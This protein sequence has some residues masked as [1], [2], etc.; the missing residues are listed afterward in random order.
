TPSRKLVGTTFIP[1]ASPRPKFD[2]QNPF[3]PTTPKVSRAP[4]RSS[5]P[6]TPSTIIAPSKRTLAEAGGAKHSFVPPGTAPKK[7]PAIHAF[8]PSKPT[9]LQLTAD[10]DDDDNYISH[11]KTYETLFEET[12]NGSRLNDISETPRQGI[13]LSFQS[14]GIPETPKISI[15]LEKDGQFR[16]FTLDP[17]ILPSKTTLDKHEQKQVVDQVKAL[18]IQLDKYLHALTGGQ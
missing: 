1:R 11:Y 6:K 12:P 2:N 13:R 14:D 3:A 15:P 5:V 16:L 18:Q 9:H 8:T 7:Y 17:G 4:S 10:W